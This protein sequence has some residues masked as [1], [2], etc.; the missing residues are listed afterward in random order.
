MKIPA[1]PPPLIMPPFAAL[2]HMRPTDDAGKYRHWDTFRRLKPPPG[3]TSEDWWYAVKLGRI[4]LW[5]GLPLQTADGAPFVFGMPDVAWEMLHRI[6]Q[7]A[8]G[9]IG[10]AEAVANPQLRER[11]V[12]SSLIEEA[13]T[14]SQL[15]GASTTRVVAKEMIRS[16][17]A[18]R[19]RSELM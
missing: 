5:K 10:A 14:S 2:E 15:E 12:M 4:A 1:A 17:R 18:P 8:A 9:R 3:L 13:I 6:D 19:D 11:Y 16:G 7:Q